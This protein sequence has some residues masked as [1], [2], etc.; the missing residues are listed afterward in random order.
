MKIWNKI[1][2]EEN[3]DKLISIPCCFKFFSPHPYYY[4]GA[5]YSEERGLWKLREE[6]V[7]RLIKADAY[8]KLKEICKIYI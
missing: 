7:K 2:I 5:P 3:K 6:V 1:P 8:L 4:L